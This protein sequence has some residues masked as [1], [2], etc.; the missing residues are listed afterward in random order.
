M[1]RL[2]VLILGLTLVSTACGETE[3]PVVEPG[4]IALVGGQLIDGTGSAPVADSVV[5]IRD[6]RIASDNAAVSVQRASFL[7]QE[8]WKGEN[9]QV[10]QEENQR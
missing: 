3:A 1:K 2:F 10:S 5:V 6:G 8:L 4:G 7:C 9:G